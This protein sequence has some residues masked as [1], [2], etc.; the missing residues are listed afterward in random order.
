MKWLWALGFP[1]DEDGR[2]VDDIRRHPGIEDEATIFD[3]TA[4][5]GKGDH[6]GLL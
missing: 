2:P 4:M 5:A 3:Q 6:V 1:L